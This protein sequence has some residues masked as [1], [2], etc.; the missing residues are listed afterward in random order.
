M[1]AESDEMRR[2]RN[3]RDGIG[4]L[5]AYRWSMFLDSHSKAL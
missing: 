3:D 2:T 5:Q 1:M 4:G